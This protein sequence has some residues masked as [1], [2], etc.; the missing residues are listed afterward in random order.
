MC[1]FFRVRLAGGISLTL[2]NSFKGSGL[3]QPNNIKVHTDNVWAE[4]GFSGLLL[5]GSIQNMYVSYF[6]IDF[7]VHYNRSRFSAQNV[8]LG[9]SFFSVNTHQPSFKVN[10]ITFQ[11]G[12]LVNPCSNSNLLCDKLRP[13]AG[14]GF[15]YQL[16]RISDV[17]FEPDYGVGGESAAKGPGYM[18]KIGTDYTFTNGYFSALEI[19]YHN[20]SI[21]TD[22]FRSFNIEGID[23]NFEVL[24]VMVLFGKSF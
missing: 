24:S 12:L 4:S 13:Y 7:G 15:T 16:A 11:I 8:K 21:H 23:G 2:Q 20:S 19:N 18:I 17:N 3:H 14:L 1:L 5:T 10:S 6:G 22:K 9:Y